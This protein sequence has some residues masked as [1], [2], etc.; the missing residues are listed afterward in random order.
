MIA[1][2]KAIRCVLASRLDRKPSWRG[3]VEWK[4]RPNGSVYFDYGTSWS[5]SAE[6]LALTV[7]PNSSGTANLRPEFNRS[8]D[9]GTK[10]DPAGRAFAGTARCFQ[11]DQ[12]YRYSLRR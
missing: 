1:A 7:G 6:T 2:L 5:P 8:Y 10:C 4:P 11:D 9:A 3:A 12:S